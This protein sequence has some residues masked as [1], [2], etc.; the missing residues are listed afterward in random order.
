MIQCSTSYSSLLTLHLSQLSFLCV[1]QPL[2]N[3]FSMFLFCLLWSSPKG[4]QT[5]C[6]LQ[7]ILQI[8]YL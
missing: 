7:G 4:R 2:T 8:S 6:Y 5:W 3:S 1:Y